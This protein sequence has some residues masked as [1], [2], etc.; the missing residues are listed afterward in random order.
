MC[1]KVEERPNY[2]TFLCFKL[3]K[4]R[5]AEVMRS[6]LQLLQSAQVK[7]NHLLHNKRPDRVVSVVE[8][9]LNNPELTISLIRKAKD[10]FRLNRRRKTAHI[11]LSVVRETG[12]RVEFWGIKLIRQRGGGLKVLAGYFVTDPVRTILVPGSLD[13]LYIGSADKA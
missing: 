8:E 5:I 13:Q 7:Y 2:V 6:F 1:K 10:Q 4:D 12:Y 3:S 11:T 9:L